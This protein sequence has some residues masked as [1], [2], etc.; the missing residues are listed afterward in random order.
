ML[1]S[2]FLVTS[3]KRTRAYLVGLVVALM[4]VTGSMDY[5]V[6]R[7]DTLT[8]IAARYGVSVSAILEAN[9]ITNPDL[10]RVGQQLVIPGES[11]EPDRVH[12]VAAGE[13]LGKIA[14]RYETKTSV[15]AE[16][17]NIGNVNLIRVGQTLKIP[18]SSQSSS[19]SAGG[20]QSTS[21]VTGFHVVAKGENLASIAAKYGIT[22]EA[23]AKANGITNTSMIYVGARL[24][25]SGSTYVAEGTGSSS[26]YTV[27]SGDTLGRIAANHGVTVRDL[28][29]ANGIANTNVIRI[30]QKLK[31]PGATGW[32][33]PVPGG[34]YVND[35]GF[36]R[37]GGRF[38]EGTDLFAPRGT[39]VRA[40]VSGTLKPITGTV[41]GLQFYLYGDDGVT[42]IGTHMDGF[43]RSGEVEAGEVI[44]YIGDTG[45]ARGGPT[46]LHFEIHPGDGAATNPFPTLQK[47]GC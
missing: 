6:K 20:E 44:G 7:G 40:P 27:K 31:I 14:S 43:G 13:T 4:V 10:I 39:E 8:S 1:A 35:W 15:L 34:T 45:N 18:G 2:L 41:G 33:C 19:G 25:L 11:G 36:P 37:S 16:L 5:S 30:G 28:A 29:S 24:A 9:D 32:V 23:L 12:V 26:S 21:G 3:D 46:H 17:N 38:H 22:V 42:Y 47:A